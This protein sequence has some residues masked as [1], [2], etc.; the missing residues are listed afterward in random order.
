MK[1][2]SVKGKVD[3]DVSPELQNA[4]S[5][6]SKVLYPL[7]PG[8]EISALVTMV[9]RTAI[10]YDIPRD[11]FLDALGSGYDTFKLMLSEGTMH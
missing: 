7:P 5:D 2:L 6:L 9:C 10:A 11:V 1:P 3:V 4:C 8:I